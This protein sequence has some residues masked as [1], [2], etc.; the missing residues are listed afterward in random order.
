MTAPQPDEKQK[1]DEFPFHT[2]TPSPKPPAIQVEDLEQGRIDLETNRTL[3][4]ATT[5]SINTAAPSTSGTSGTSDDFTTATAP[6]F[7][8]STASIALPKPS[9]NPSMSSI[10]IASPTR[11]NGYPSPSRMATYDTTITSVS[12]CSQDDK[13]I[14]E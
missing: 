1:Q 8:T 12:M 14:R 11:P 2:T 7:A 3:S 4:T 10:R 5:D 9:V 6:S 13:I